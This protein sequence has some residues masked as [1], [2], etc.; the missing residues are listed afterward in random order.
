MF[1]LPEA[2]FLLALSFHDRRSLGRLHTA[3]LWG[4]GLLL[5]SAF[6]RTWVAETGVWLAC[7]DAVIR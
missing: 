5:T 6:S 2:M 4:G 1:G 3:T 7:A